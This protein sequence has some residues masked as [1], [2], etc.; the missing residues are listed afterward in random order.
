MERVRT[1]VDEPESLH[2][3][4]SKRSGLEDQILRPDDDLSPAFENENEVVFGLAL[5]KT[6][7]H[8]ISFSQLHNYTW[9]LETKQE[10]NKT[11]RRKIRRKK[12]NTASQFHTFNKTKR[13]G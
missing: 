11:S 9:R 12:E 1:I 10:K 6:K 4:R 13:R 2:A 3:K 8:G 5:W 7:I